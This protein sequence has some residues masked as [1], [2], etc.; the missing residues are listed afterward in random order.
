MPCGSRKPCA[1]PAGEVYMHVALLYLSG[2]G[3]SGGAKTT[4]RM[5]VPRLLESDAIS[6][7]DLL[8]PQGNDVNHSMPLPVWSWPKWDQWLG[9]P[10]LKR[11]VRSLRPDVI[12]I[13]TSAWVDFDSAPVLCMVRN[14]EAVTRP[15][16]NNPF[17]VGLK[18]VLRRD[19]A[20]R[21]CRKADRVIAVSQYVEDFLVNTWK[22]PSEK[23]AVVY[24]GL[25]DPLPEPACVPPP[26]IDTGEA[27][28]FW[29]TAGSLLAYRGL[30]DLVDALAIR[31]RQ[32]KQDRLA[33]AGRDVYSDAYRRSIIQ[34]AGCAGIADRILWLGHVTPPQMA[35]CFR[36]C[37][38]FVMTSRLEACPNTVLEALNYAAPSISTSDPPMPEFFGDAALYYTPRSGEELARCMDERDSMDEDQVAALRARATQRAR[39]FRIEQTVEDTIAQIQRV[40]RDRNPA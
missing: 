10:V 36:H 8:L 25:T 5:L 9:F 13:P 24:H 18:N 1:I 26:G 17:F 33:I 30:E 21:A 27:G 3:L 40:A 20:R 35:W 22:I 19:M 37:R 38:A 15:F 11:R 32:G 39:D 28:D 23:T 4:L 12:F 29:F 16:G 31:S 6:R 2:G 34:R 14:M 7:M